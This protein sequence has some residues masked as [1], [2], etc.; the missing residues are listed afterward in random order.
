MIK[1]KLNS[2]TS[3]FLPL[4]KSVLLGLEPEPA[5]SDFELLNHIGS[6]TFG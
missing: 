1:P 3:R 6:G 4:S 5:I 2:V